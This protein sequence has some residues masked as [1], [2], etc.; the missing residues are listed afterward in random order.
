MMKVYIETYGCA[1]NQAESEIMAG[2]LRQAGQEIAEE[3]QAD[4]VIIA[5]CHVK[6][7]TEQKIL[8]RISRIKKR[9]VVAGCMPEAYREK[10]LSVR[11]DA[12]LVST[13]QIHRITEAL[14]KRV[15]FL[16]SSGKEKAC[17][18]RIRKD[19][20]IAIV[21][22][23]DGC[24]GSC[25][26]C[27][28]RLA[29]GKLFSFKPSSIVKEIDHAVRE[30]CREVWLTAQDTGAY[31]LDIG[32]SLP[33][34]LSILPE[35]N[36]RVRIGMMNPDHVLP[37]LNK[38]IESYRDKKIMKFLHVPV[39]SGDDMM[40]RAMNR[41]YTVDDFKKIV[42]AFRNE[43]PN[44]VLWTDVIIGYPGET[45]MQFKNTL[46]LLRQ[47]RP[48]KVNISRFAKRD[49]TASAKLQ[50]LPTDEMKRRTKLVSKLFK[51]RN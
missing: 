49:R 8:D 29:K 24:L 6:K 12:S 9:L 31:G 1:A 19:K 44:L 38:L 35:G 21:Q 25:S 4:I 37:I 26:Y 47:I 34:L 28:V 27:A 10:I 20:N 2:L 14:D 36:Y 15:E 11:P 30:G 45:P 48:N 39:Q 32:T 7:V 17:L 5:S 46:D 22:I 42:D 13:H 51:Y 33:H 43:F 23:A 3:E 16:G 50:Q 18:P 40:L 41:Q